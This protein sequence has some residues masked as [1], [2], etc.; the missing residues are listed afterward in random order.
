MEYM[1]RISHRMQK[2]KFNVSS[3]NMF[4]METV[5]VPPEQEK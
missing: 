3:L 5:L 2:H 1:T 4:F